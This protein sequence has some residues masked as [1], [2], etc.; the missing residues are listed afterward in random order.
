MWAVCLNFI[1]CFPSSTKRILGANYQFDN[2]P[3][4]CP[5]PLGNLIRQVIKWC[6]VSEREEEKNSVHLLLTGLKERK[7]D[8]L[9]Q[10]QKT[11]IFVSLS[12]L[13]FYT[14]WEQVIKS[15]QGALTTVP[16]LQAEEKHPPIFS[17]LRRPI[18]Y[19]SFNTFNDKTFVREWLHFLFNFYIERLFTH[20]L[21]HSACWV[22]YGLQDVQQEM[23]SPHHSCQRGRSY[24]GLCPQLHV[25]ASLETPTGLQ[26]EFYSE[27]LTLKIIYLNTLSCCHYKMLV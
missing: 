23:F 6:P 26:S 19:F 18:H 15:S 16:Q 24:S 21:F 12:K 2:I 1:S 20:L 9:R 7:K 3:P 14:D 17:Q 25:E 8:I 5:R 27:Y 4:R 22:C 10:P 13:L 11:Y